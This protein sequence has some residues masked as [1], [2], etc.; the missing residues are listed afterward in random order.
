MGPAQQ[1]FADSYVGP[2]AVFAGYCGD[3]GEA[4]AL[5]TAEL[6]DCAS[7]GWRCLA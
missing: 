3:C 5:Q 2:V 7:Q 6:Q 4:C 1:V